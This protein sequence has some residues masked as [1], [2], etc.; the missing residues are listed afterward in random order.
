MLFFSILKLTEISCVEN[1]LPHLRN[2]RKSLKT[3]GFW[4]RLQ[5]RPLRAPVFLGSLTRQ[6]E[7]CAPPPAQR[8]FAAFYSY[9]KIKIIFWT[10]AAR[11]FSF[12]STTKATEYT[13]V[14]GL[15][16]SRRNW[17]FPTPSSES[18]CESPLGSKGGRNTLLRRR[19]RVPQ[20]IQCARP[21]FHGRPNWVPRPIT[22]KRVL[23]PPPLGP[24]GG[25]TLTFGGGGGGTNSDE[26]ALWYS[27]YTIIPQRP[28]L[29]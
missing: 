10:R 2:V 9:P 14:Q 19:G 17:V 29:W 7:H 1:Y 26:G 21:S 27:R 4:P 24:R 13:E 22:C 12:H 8:S 20:S 18:E 25:Y 5:A 3:S 11:L 6:M 28:R 16:S 15:L 23:L